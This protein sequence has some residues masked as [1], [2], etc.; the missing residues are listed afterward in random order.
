MSALS[1]IFSSVEHFAAGVEELSSGVEE[2]SSGVIEGILQKQTT[3]INKKDE[4][5]KNASGGKLACVALA[6]LSIG[7]LILGLALTC[8]ST[9]GAIF[10]VPLIAISLAGLTIGYNGYQYKQI[11]LEIAKKPINFI[12]KIDYVQ[13]GKVIVRRDELRAMIVKETFCFEYITA[14]LVTGDLDLT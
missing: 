3:H 12:S 5:Y 2:L 10:G 8:T 4:L 9:L 7:L 14:Q 1:S 11:H 13:S 6:V